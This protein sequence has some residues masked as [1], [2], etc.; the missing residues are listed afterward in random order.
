M[1]YL[2]LSYIHLNTCFPRLLCVVKVKVTQSCLTLATL[3]TVARQAALS[4]GFSRQE[5]WSGMPLPPSG[6]LPNPGIKAR[7]PA[8]QVNSLLSKPPRNPSS[9]IN[10]ELLWITFILPL[11]LS[12]VPKSSWWS[13]IWTQGSDFPGFSS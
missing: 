2:L 7:S 13:S 8:L 1:F 5:Y 6:D 9:Q 4:M 3:W 12:L 10:F 11:F